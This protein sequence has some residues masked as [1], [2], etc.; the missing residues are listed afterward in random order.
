MLQSAQPPHAGIYHVAAAGETSRHGLAAF[1]LECAQRHGMG[2]Q[3]GPG[4]VRP[5]TSD[6]F[7]RPA[8]RPANSRLDTSRVRAVFGVSLPPWQEGVDAV[9]SQWGAAREPQQ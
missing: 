7:P 5:V 8:P 6:A 3:A 1:A 4:D 2:L 9:V